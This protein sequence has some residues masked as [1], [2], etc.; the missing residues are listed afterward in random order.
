MEHHNNDAQACACLDH[1]ATAKAPPPDRT[2]QEG[3]GPKA[4]FRLLLEG[5]I[6]QEAISELIIGRVPFDQIF[7]PLIR[8]R[9][10]R[11]LW[12]HPVLDKPLSEFYEK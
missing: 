5:G 11:A 7:D 10:F 9:G 12:F 2:R 3:A 6:C 1:Q 8:F 4:G